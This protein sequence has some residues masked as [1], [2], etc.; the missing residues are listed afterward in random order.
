MYYDVKTYGQK[1]L[2]GIF[3]KQVHSTYITN[4]FFTLTEQ[5]SAK[6]CIQEP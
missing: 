1:I 4:V 5:I 3:R 6:Y 2:H